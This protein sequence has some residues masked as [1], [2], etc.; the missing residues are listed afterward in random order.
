MRRIIKT[1]S[2][3]LMIAGFAALSSC[4][5]P[6]A[7]GK[8]ISMDGPRV[9]IKTPATRQPVDGKFELS[10]DISSNNDIDRVE[11]SIKYTLE[12]SP[13]VFVDKDLGK[14]WRKA[15]TSWEVKENGS[16]SM[17]KPLVVMGEDWT[18]GEVK[19]SWNGNNKK[20]KW[21]IPINM[22]INGSIDGIPDGQYIITVTSW[23]TAG[24]SDDNSSKSR[25]VMLYKEPPRVIVV[26]P[27]IYQDDHTKLIE[28]KDVSD[29][30]KP[31][32]LGKFL[33]GS[34]DLQFQIV[35]PN[36]V[37]SID[38]RFYKSDVDWENNEDNYVYRTYINDAQHMTPV[39]DPNYYNSLLLPNYRLK[40]P[41]LS[42]EPFAEK[43]DGERRHEL[44]EKISGKNVLRAVVR[45]TNAAGM[46][47]PDDDRMQGCFVYWPESDLPFIVFPSELKPIYNATAIYTT[48]STSPVPVKAYDDDGVAKV[49]YSIYSAM[50]GSIDTEPL[51]DFEDIVPEELKGNVWSNDDGC[52]V[53]NVPKIL[54]WEYKLPV[55]AGDYYI[56][57]MVYDKYNVPGE[58]TGGFFRVKDI[59]FPDITPPEKPIST[60]PLFRYIKGQTI[61]DWKISIEGYATDNREI[62]SVQMV[63]INQKYANYAAMS[64]LSF[65]SDP[66]YLGWKAPD[67]FGNTPVVDGDPG[68]DGIFDSN[69]PNRVYNLKVVE[70]G[71][72][73]K[74]RPR[75]K[76][77]ITNLSLKDL[78]IQPGV[79]G[80]EYLKSQVFVFKAVNS[81][82]PVK[83]S[84]ITWAPQGDTEAPVIKITG[85]NISRSDGT[86]K[87]LKFHPE[88][89][90]PIKQFSGGDI[91]T[92]TGTWV[93][94][95][96][97]APDNPTDDDGDL[98]IQEVLT[99]NLFV[100]INGK[101]MTGLY[102]TKKIIFKDNPVP[103]TSGTG[104]GRSGTWEAGG[105]V[106][107]LGEKSPGVPND[108]PGTHT[109]IAENLKDT[110]VVSVNLTDVGGNTSED[111]ASWLIESDTLKL[112]RVGSDTPNGIYTTD[113]PIDIFLE[114]NRP[115]TLKNA[116]SNPVLKLALDNGEVADAIYTSNPTTPNS[117]QHF[118]YT[119]LSN[120]NRNDITVT[121]ISA[122]DSTF[123]G[124]NY[125]F[126]WVN[127]SGGTS[128]E[129]RLVINERT[130]PP[131]A[132]YQLGRIRVTTDTRDPYYIFTLQ[133]GSSIS[134]DTGG[135]VLTDVS[136]NIR[137]SWYNLDS[138][139][140][141]TVTFNEPIQAGVTL[142]KL[143]MNINNTVNGIITRTD[144]RTTDVQINGNRAI[145]SYTVAAGDYT[146]SYGDLR[147]TGIEGNI[148]DLAGNAFNNELTARTFTGVRVDSI[149]PLAPTLR[150]LSTTSNEVGT[151][152]G[153]GVT[154]WTPG[155][156]T[157][158]DA[159]ND[160]YLPSNT[161]IVKLDNV[162]YD[163]LYIHI[164]PTGTDE[165][166]HSKIEYSVNYG[167]DWALY[168]YS[169]PNNP[170]ERVN[171]GRYDL[172]ARQIDAAGNVSNWSK[173]ITLNWDKGAL[174]TRITTDLTNG[175]YTRNDAGR[176][177]VIPIKLIFRVPVKFTASP[178]LTLNARS[179]T[180]GPFIT[181]TLASGDLNTTP[182]TEHIFNYPVGL[183]DTTEGDPL[184]VKLES[185]QD[186][187][188]SAQDSKGVNVTSMI[189][190]TRVIEK[191]QKFE[192][193]KEI[194]IQTGKPLFENIEITGT[195]TDDDTYNA[196]L[197]IQFDRSIYRGD[198]YIG[199]NIDN[200]NV[201][202][203]IQSDQ[204]DARYRL[205]AILTES[206]RTLF[207]T[208][209]HP[210][211]SGD[212]GY[213]PNLDLDTYYTKGTSGYING[214]G[215]DT[216]A[217]YILNFDHDTY[218]IVPDSSGGD[219]TEFAY[220]FRMAERITLP[221]NSSAITVNDDT[222]IVSLQGSNALKV[223]GAKYEINYGT[224]FIVD[225]LSNPCDAR[226]EYYTVSGVSRPTIRIRKPDET[227]T[228]DS[229]STNTPKFKAVQPGTAQIRIDNRTPN[230][231]V[232]YT[233][234]GVEQSDASIGVCFAGEANNPI[235]Y[236]QPTG[237]PTQPVD[238]RGNTGTSYGNTTTIIPLP[239]GT[240]ADTT[241][242]FIDCYKGYKYR[243]RAV[244][245]ASDGTM[246]P[247]N[248]NIPDAEE[249]AYRT[250][251][252]FVA[253]GMTVDKGQI[254]GSGDQLW[255]RGSNTPTATTIPGFPLTPE[256]NWKD[257]KTT[258]KRAGIRLMSKHNKVLG[259]NQSHSL[260]TC[261]WQWVTWNANSTI[262]F[263]FYLGRD[264]API[265]DTV[266]T[267]TKY[268]PKNFSIHNGNWSNMRELYLAFPG[269]R[270]LLQSDSPDYTGQGARQYAY[271]FNTGFSSRPDP[272]EIVIV[273]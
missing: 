234:N 119:V 22:E 42:E 204:P 238:P 80:Y 185:Y 137:A 150:V 64:Q 104:K 90:D 30:K 120:H 25:V 133:G 211:N 156:Y 87:N 115:V 86:E 110:L 103:G 127:T 231:Y 241:G 58:E 148:E 213:N 228:L 68:L 252:V 78:N 184:T 97:S 166:D 260:N 250:V 12:T 118:T 10:G 56:K 253:N 123:N 236:P 94:D 174:L 197:R 200:P 219:I 217:K 209:I 60:V 55:K 41:D 248:T 192:D 59:N 251:I 2:I 26:L 188:F 243:I 108:D 258:D 170:K 167:K 247:L 73:T 227:I 32:Y 220:A 121:G 96:A 249:I 57:V 114:F 93:E 51:D 143:V 112:L 139:L 109:L 136:P 37:W 198:A 102:E 256:D 183:T 164:A 181:L 95:S 49:V 15:G 70:D 31:E 135:P 18:E 155:N 179:S 145:F 187:P 82:N 194:Y 8:Q 39:S 107:L 35:D 245:V 180:N 83:T 23:D 172:T 46:K 61:A 233:T 171:Q 147:I 75:F 207:K 45:C 221:I 65:F 230:S 216:T 157:D 89:E 44:K 152:G 151:S 264:N 195:A 257:I 261:L 106:L 52:F 189:N 203:I 246:P 72:D 191:E 262:Y 140:Y 24:N 21:T 141:F 14:Q 111:V 235:A 91:I 117:K 272:S 100:E 34:F 38:I 176:A 196:T 85:V 92:V 40:V 47:L 168:D 29:W 101:R 113:K 158:S 268:G 16:W 27:K 208:L 182:K 225:I 4:D 126:S 153:V 199:G 162:Y 128:E 146:A 28:L 66:D 13:G 43:K 6:I 62:K 214:T 54:P 206:Q 212:A 88:P 163:N 169:A 67:K 178:T 19:P 173:P 125:P 224:G 254:F 242:D 76:Y 244:G 193:L 48:F 270:R 255:L 122:D 154:P 218:N 215:S 134:V 17:V 265:G 20:A 267:V 160:S 175:I 63:W 239:I 84:I 9:E 130:L 223:L 202:T 53:G 165:S 77:S 266:D 132:E 71:F 222:V 131:N 273:P 226:T 98:T 201:I 81:D 240:P 149:V 186:F 36:D 129:I 263:D 269:Q 74:G 210:Y 159:F 3:L 271:N 5:N 69:N 232:R 11:V 79:D 142:P 259:Q 144:T 33:S 99:K 50:G 190:M 116:G 205:P 138:P 229:P 1:G 105:T 237:A 161:N 177:D 7:L 124:T